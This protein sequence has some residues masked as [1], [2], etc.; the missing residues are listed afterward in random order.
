[1]TILALIYMFVKSKSDRPVQLA[2]KE[3]KYKE[4]IEKI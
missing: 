3:E 2:F 4:M 1:M